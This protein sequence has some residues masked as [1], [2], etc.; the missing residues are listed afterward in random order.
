MTTGEDIATKDDPCG[1]YY[2]N[3]TVDVRFHGINDKFYPTVKKWDGVSSTPKE[4]CA[5]LYRGSS[6][7]KYDSYPNA[8]I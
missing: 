5:C 3:G 4:A 8:D 2:V 6:L 1:K 7:F